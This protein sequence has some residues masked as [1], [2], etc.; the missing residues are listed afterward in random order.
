MRIKQVLSSLSHLIF[1]KENQIKIGKSSQIKHINRF[2]LTMW[3]KK[4]ELNETTHSHQKKKKMSKRERMSKRKLESEK[5]KRWLRVS[6]FNFMLL[7]FALL[8]CFR[9]LAIL[10]KGDGVCGAE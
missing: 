7:L 9:L 6:R 8:A 2:D 3:K 10:L 4:P 1:D 5:E